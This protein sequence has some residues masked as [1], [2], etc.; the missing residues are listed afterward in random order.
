MP[1]Q[2]YYIGFLKYDKQLIW[3]VANSKLEILHFQSNIQ[4][5][6]EL[7]HL[8]H[9]LA[10]SLSFVGSQMIPINQENPK[11]IF[12]PGLTGLPHLKYNSIKSDAIRKFD[13][14]YAMN[15]SFAF[16]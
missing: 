4:I 12:K 10:G 2:L 13:N 16:D 3:S 11:I 8:Y 1:I 14:Y 7:P 9:I 5:I 6:Q 15:Y